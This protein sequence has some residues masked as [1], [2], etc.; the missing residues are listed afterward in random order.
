MVDAR[1]L[2]NTLTRRWLNLSLRIKG[3]A[4]LALPLVSLLVSLTLI[5]RLEQARTDTEQ[6][7]KRIEEVRAQ[8]QNMFIYLISAESEVRNFGLNGR[9]DG[10]YP[11]SLTLAAIDPVFAKAKDLMGGN[12]EQAARLEKLKLLVHSRFEGLKQLREY[13][14]SPEA[15]SKVAPDELRARARISPDVILS[16]NE[17]AQTE[18]K[19]FQEAAKADSDRQAR[20]RIWILISIASGVL[21]GVLG[22]L[23]FTRSITRRMERLERTAS[24][25]AEGLPSDSE[26]RRNDELGRLAGAIERAGAVIASRSQELKLALEG[27][28]VLIWELD[29]RAAGASA[30]TPVR[31]HSRVRRCRRNC[32]PK[33]PMRGSRWFIPTIAST[34]KSE[35]HRIA[36]ESA[37]FQIEYRVVV[38]GGAIRWMIV[39]AQS[40]GS[41]T[42]DRRLL[43]VLADITD[44]K[45]AS[46]EIERQAR[47]LIGSREA[48]QRQTRILQSIL[49]SMGDGVIVADTQGKFLVFNPAA[50]QIM[51]ARSF[52]EDADQ[53]SKQHGLF[54][55]D[56]VT[57]YPA[58]QLPFVRSIRGESVDAAEIFVRPAGA[59]EGNWVSVNARPLR[60]EDGEIRGGVVV[61]R[62]ITAQKHAAE[63]LQLAK[64]E[65]ESAN[66]AKSEF[67]SRMSHELAHAA[68]FDSRLRP[69]SRTRRS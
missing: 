27:G 66:H 41:G 58:D 54:L 2:L 61:I 56:M 45:I 42:G 40:Y 22:V 55:P 39:K 32:C 3:M 65:A 38:R 9:E 8:L 60:T 51:G 44:R 29:P 50:R 25:L 19:L 16:V 47:E 20:L 57:L 30:I 63:A 12:R 62:N 69:A 21:G 46:E 37:Y 53:W 49:D 10:L 33:R 64:Q 35:L 48:L 11:F 28:G 59:S 26:S 24:R 7:V 13:Y 18:S 43:G 36:S 34:S 23:L 5:D 67:L 31:K 17:L 68:E 15:R 4:I 52:G 14:A 6:R 1:E